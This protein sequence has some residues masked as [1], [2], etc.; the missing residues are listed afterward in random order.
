LEDIKEVNTE[1]INKEIKE[2]N[3]EIEQEKKASDK[4]LIG[5]IT[6]I[7]LIIAVIIGMQ[8]L[9]EEE[10]PKTIDDLH[11]LNLKGKLKAEEGYV[12]DQVIVLY[13]RMIYGIL[14]FREAIIYMT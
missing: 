11:S 2:T 3:I 13:L 9:Q 10:T 7:I 6:V 12:T 8:Y 1:E 14:K 4:I 5:A